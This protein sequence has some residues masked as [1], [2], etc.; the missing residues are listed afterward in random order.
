MRRR[1]RLTGIL[2]VLGLIVAVKL[3]QQ[4]YA[5]FAYAD[6]RAA[7]QA[8]STRLESSG[9]EVIRTQLAA[10]SLRGDI[11]RMDRELGEKKQV[12][13]SFERHV[14]DGALPAHLYDAY[15]AELQ[16]Y[17]RQV[18]QRNAKFGR[19][20]EIV[21]RNHAAVGTYNALADS[22]RTL[23]NRIGEPYFEIPSPV[24]LAVK[25]GLIGG[26]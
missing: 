24:E 8:I 1:E 4:L 18:E 26:R 19:W 13:G 23:A 11:E 5:W 25:H 12:V 3:G 9:L 21:V 7:L 15:S 22:I 14:R 10:D 20:K 16:S 17:N 2:L 6:E